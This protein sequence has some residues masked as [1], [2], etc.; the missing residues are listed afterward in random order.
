MADEPSEI[1][2][3][4]VTG[5]SSMALMPTGGGDVV[6]QLN[7]AAT[8][9]SLGWPATIAAFVIGLLIMPFGLILWALAAPLCWWLFLRDQARRTVVLFYDVS[10]APAAWFDHLVTNWNWLIQSQMTWRILQSGKVQTT[11]QHKTNAGAYNLVNRVLA[12]AGTTGPRHL[13]TNVAV[14]SIAAGKTSLYFLPDRILVRD[15]KHYSDISY[16]N[17]VARGSKNQ[18]IETT[19]PPP[20]DSVQVGQTWKYVNVKGGPDRRYS[21]NPVLPVM[22]YGTIEIT[23]PQGLTWLIQTSR[24]ESAE[25]ISRALVR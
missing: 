22:L 13:S 20:H 2:M 7:V 21:N 17:L 1:V 25:A 12:S 10:D 16:E 24:A 6:E 5:V 3:E 14:P 11:Y 9:I 4:D 18:F 19:G 8:R 15:D 23:S